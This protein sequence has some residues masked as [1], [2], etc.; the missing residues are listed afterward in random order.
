MTFKGA[1]ASTFRIIN[2]SS[3]EIK[4]CTIDL[5]GIDG[6]NVSDS[7]STNI[8]ISNCTISNSN[9][10]AIQANGSTNWI[11]KNNIITRTGLNRGMGMSGD[12]QYIAISK[13]GSNS[14][15]EFNDIKNTGYIGIDFHGDNILIKNNFIDSFCLVKSDGGGIYTWQK[16][17]E[18]IEKS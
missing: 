4:N 12:G 3:I 17:P 1:N 7:R 18:G 5:S 2:S 15:V 11:I 8:T 9:S 10:N 13:L 6:V 16:R 14:S